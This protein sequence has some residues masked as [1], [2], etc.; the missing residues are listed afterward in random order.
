MTSLEIDFHNLKL[1][2]N[3]Y[4]YNMALEIIQGNPVYTVLSG[5]KWGWKDYTG[6]VI[7]ILK[8]LG[9]KYKVGNN[10]PRKGKLGTFVE[11]TKADIKNYNINKII[12]D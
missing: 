10:F 6:D 11:V 4:K 5:T 2:K 12:S 9:V 7:E 3:S 1:R 8:I